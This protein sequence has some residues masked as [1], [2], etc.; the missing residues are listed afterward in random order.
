MRSDTLKKKI[1]A[2]PLGS[3][4]NIYKCG[5]GVKIFIKKPEKIPTQLKQSDRYDPKK[6]FQIGLN[7]KDLPE[8]LPNHLRILIDLYLKNKEDSERAEKL[9]DAIEKIYEGH[10]PSRLKKEM[11]KLK[12]EEKIEEN[13]TILCLAQLH[14]IEQD[15]NYDFGKV[16]PPRAYLMGYIRMIRLEAEEIDKILWSS[17]RHPP[18][19][20]YRSKECLKPESN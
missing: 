16:K 17:T 10:D 8:F 11:N 7:K 12:F 3:R 14:M 6:N 2:M 15:I 5:N 18:R 4:K 13:F 1:I 20:K 19:V 9:F